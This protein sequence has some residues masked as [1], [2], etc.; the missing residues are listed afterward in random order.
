MFILS[1]PSRVQETRFKVSTDPQPKTAEP[2][3]GTI[4]LCVLALFLGGLGKG[5]KELPV[6]RRI[7]REPEPKESSAFDYS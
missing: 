5:N 1:V 2:R 3:T 7:R 4:L 6:H